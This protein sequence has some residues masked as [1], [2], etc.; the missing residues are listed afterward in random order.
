MKQQLIE[1]ISLILKVLELE[2]K[3]AA[4]GEDYSR[5][6][7]S[8]VGASTGVGS[9]P[10]EA[11]RRLPKA[12]ARAVLSGHRAPITAVAVH[13]VYRY[14]PAVHLTHTLTHSLT[15]SLT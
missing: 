9:G 3:V 15:H 2:A 5:G 10:Q 14:Y 7:D 11:T 8:S 12:P 6:A 4:R 1:Q 13:P